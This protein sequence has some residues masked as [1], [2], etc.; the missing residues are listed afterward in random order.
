MS[1]S[2]HTPQNS[3]NCLENNFWR[4]SFIVT[5]YRGKPQKYKQNQN[6]EQISPF[7][8]KGSSWLAALNFTN[9]DIIRPSLQ[10]I[11]ENLK[12]LWH[13]KLAQISPFLQ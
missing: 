10:A 12:E 1:K 11:E 4:Y 6:L 7:L 8:Q 2:D 9:I 13:K 5:S 3:S